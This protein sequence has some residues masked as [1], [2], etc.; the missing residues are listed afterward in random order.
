MPLRRAHRGLID[1]LKHAMGEGRRARAAAGERKPDHHV[2]AGGRIAAGSTAK[3]AA[4]LPASGWL[5]GSLTPSDAQPASQTASAE[6][7][8]TVRRNVEHPDQ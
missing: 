7:G 5:V 3:A 2:I 4:A 8:A 6:A 1:L